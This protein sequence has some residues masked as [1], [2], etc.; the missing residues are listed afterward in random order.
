MLGILEN[1]GTHLPNKVQLTVGGKKLTLKFPTDAGR[2]IKLSCSKN[3]V[4]CTFCV[5]KLV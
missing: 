4:K 2:A 5:Y 3:T 1:F